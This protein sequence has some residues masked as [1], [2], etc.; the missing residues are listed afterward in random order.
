MTPTE[1]M[2]ETTPFGHLDDSHFNDAS[3]LAALDRL[4]ALLN[5]PPAPSNS[6]APVSLPTYPTLLGAE[7]SRKARR[8]GA[9]IRFRTPD[10]VLMKAS[11]LGGLEVVRQVQ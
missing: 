8:E 4:Y 9:E 1:Y 11:P 10:G 7:A 2:V 5:E 6:L 3:V